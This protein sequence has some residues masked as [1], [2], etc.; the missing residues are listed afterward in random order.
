MSKLTAII[1]HKCPR[2]RQ[3][4]TF[5][6]SMFSLRYARMHKLCPVC[7][8]KFEIEPGFFYA[9]MYVSYVFIVAE[10]ITSGILAFMLF[11]DTQIYKIFFVTLSPTLLLFTFNFRYART[12]LL[13]FLAPVKFDRSYA[14]KVQPHV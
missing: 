5:T 12:L 7:N 10:L 9:S 13:H 4:E 14:D 8:L 6:D 3:G 2:C 11:N 1:H